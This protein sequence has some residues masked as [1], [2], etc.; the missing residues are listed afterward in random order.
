MPA[1]GRWDLIRRLKDKMEIYCEGTQSI[2]YNCKLF[3]GE[4]SSIIYS[5]S[6]VVVQYALDTVYNLAVL[7]NMN[8]I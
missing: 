2:S 1:N 7:Q 3:C 5:V 4:F 6:A 8:G